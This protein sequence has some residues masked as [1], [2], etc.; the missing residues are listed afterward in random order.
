MSLNEAPVPAE[1]GFAVVVREMGEEDE[2]GK[3]YN[4][5]SVRIN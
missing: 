3:F 1:D 4:L 5:K 2:I